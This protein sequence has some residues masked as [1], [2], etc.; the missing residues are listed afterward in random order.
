M[1]QL[2]VYLESEVR[3]AGYKGPLD[4]TWQDFADRF[5]DV[6]SPEERRA[7]LDALTEW[8][9]TVYVRH[10][11]TE[12]FWREQYEEE[13]P[14]TKEQEVAIFNA[15]R[16]GSADAARWRDLFLYRN[17]ALVMWVVK[18]FS[19]SLGV[20]KDWDKINQELPTEKDILMKV[21]MVGL[22]KAVERFD[23]SRGHSFST[24]AVWWIRGEITA[25]FKNIE[26]AKRKLLKGVVWRPAYVPRVEEDYL[27]LRCAVGQ[28]LDRL[29]DPRRAQIII[30]RYGL[31]GGKGKTPY[32]A[33]GE[34]LGVSAQR[35]QQ[36]LPKILE[37]LKQDEELRAFHVSWF[38]R[39]TSSWWSKVG[40]SEGE[41]RRN[42]KQLLEGDADGDSH[43]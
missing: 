16:D 13:K 40:S 26:A 38:R 14:L 41:K 7:A 31:F 19:G 24:Y 3:N 10:L 21:G 42:G 12:Q 1:D 33:I 29:N 35:V 18:S 22:E 25:L 6:V 4:F 5:L 8:Y 20:G 39:S 9:R 23:P 11:Y 34:A 15:M 37:E 30:M 32:R 17:K 43:V 2:R 36:M 27:E 28:A